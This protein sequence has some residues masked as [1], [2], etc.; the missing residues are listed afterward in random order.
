[1]AKY[2]FPKDFVWG[3]STAAQQIEGAVNQDG[4]GESVWDVFARRP[5]AIHE[6]LNAD[7]ACDHYNRYAGDVALMKEIGL[8]GYRFS[9]S[10]PRIMPSGVGPVNKAGL[11]FYDRL[12]DSLL[13][14]GI[15]PYLTLY[16]WDMPYALAP[17]GGWMNPDSPKWF[18]DYASVVAGHLGDRVRWWMTFNEQAPFLVGGYLDGWHAPGFKAGWREFL[19]ACKNVMLA[20]GD[21]VR[22]V[23][24]SAPK[25][26]KV[27]MAPVAMLGIP[28][29]ES[30]QD[31]EAARSFTFDLSKR[32][33]WH[34][35]LY[36]E[37][38][39]T[40][41]LAP[42]FAE[43]FG[44]DAPS[45]TDA[46]LKAMSPPLDFLGLN[47]YNAPYARAGENGPEEVPKEPGW[48]PA[49][50]YWKITP[51][52]LYWCVR[53]Y[54]ERYALPVVITENGLSCQDWVALDGR[55]HDAPR[56]DATARYL[57]ALHRAVEEGFP[58]L[59]YFHWSLMDNFE[60]AEGYKQRF[61]LIHVDFRTLERTIKDSGYWYADI[62]RKS[63]LES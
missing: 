25:P 45:F 22:A 10:W 52:G 35:A 13:E 32:D 19:L 60:W 48:P 18:A 58:V 47:F 4:R 21:A 38:V 51:D 29:S 12:V 40:G 16:H 9:V 55:V 43:I 3:A 11:D 24:A 2:E 26:P 44:S 59:G 46:E 56:I 20:H 7:I 49:G 54:H 34:P 39:L 62:V 42:N 41:K 17:K 27:G 50:Q 33:N 28:A 37:P 15:E 14:A 57:I 53:M 36:I 23:R 61:G 63:A 30:V 1:M 8:K 6:G 5:G 31:I